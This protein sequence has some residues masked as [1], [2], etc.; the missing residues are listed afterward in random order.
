MFRSSIVLVFT[1]ETVVLDPP[2]S[3][4]SGPR[5]TRRVPGWPSEQWV[6]CLGCVSC[7][8]RHWRPRRRCSLHFFL[9]LLHFLLRL[10][11]RISSTGT[12][13]GAAARD[14]DRS[15]P[16]GGSGVG[17]CAG[18]GTG[19]RRGRVTDAASL[20]QDVHSLRTPTVLT[21]RHLPQGS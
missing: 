3:L 16:G 13:K 12:G 9:L 5:G 6:P 2:H 7:P 19:G 15:N 10:P 8:A 14:R 20:V 4:F 18:R 1:M 21:Q 11:F 17:R